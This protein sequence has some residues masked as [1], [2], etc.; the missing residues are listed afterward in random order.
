M[1]SC[2][3]SDSNN[4]LVEIRQIKYLIMIKISYNLISAVRCLFIGKCKSANKVSYKFVHV[5]L[6]HFL[7]NRQINKLYAHVIKINVH[8]TN[9]QNNLTY[10]K[11]VCLNIHKL[12]NNTEEYC[13]KL[14]SVNFFCNKLFHGK[15][16]RYRIFKCL[17][18]IYIFLMTETIITHK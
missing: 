5:T 3:I 9:T 6:I 8:V 11:V 10:R 15:H 4:I 12:V 2:V 17:L 13:H 7:I 1:C 14:I 16:G 18:T